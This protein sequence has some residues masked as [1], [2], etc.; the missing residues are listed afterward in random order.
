MTAKDPGAAYLDLAGKPVEISFLAMEYYALMFNRT[1]AVVVTRNSIQGAKMFGTVGS[2]RGGFSAAMWRDP[3]NF[4]DP[5]TRAKYEG[6][7]PESPPFLSIHKDNFR[8]PCTQVREIRFS[9]RKKFSMGGIP[10]SGSLLV[11][12]TDGKKREFILLG[13]QDGPNIQS[14]LLALCP[15]ASQAPS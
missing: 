4:V 1:F 5:K 12:T 2:P 3:R 13:Q 11:T 9:S 8:I 10:H 6:V 7:D 15:T 14:R